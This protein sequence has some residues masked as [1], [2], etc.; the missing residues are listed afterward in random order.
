MFAIVVQQLVHNIVSVNRNTAVNGSFWSRH[1][2]VRLLPRPVGFQA[3]RG[4]FFHKQTRDQSLKSYQ[5]SHKY[6]SLTCLRTSR[7]NYELFPWQ[8]ISCVLQT[9]FSLGRV[10]DFGYLFSGIQ[11]FCKITLSQY[12]Y[13][14]NFWR[15]IRKSHIYSVSFLYFP[16]ERMFRISSRLSLPYPCQ[17]H[18]WKSSTSWQSVSNF[19]FSS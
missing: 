16:L 3:S 17:Y 5:Q 7:V 19:A 4:Q 15:T 10:G 1:H 8:R 13:I 14:Q 18:L 11:S 6:H 2:S 12:A 9:F